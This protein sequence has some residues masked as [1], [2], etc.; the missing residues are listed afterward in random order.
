MNCQNTIVFHSIGVVRNTNTDDLYEFDV[1]YATRYNTLN[2][3]VDKRTE[4]SYEMQ[5]LKKSDIEIRVNKPYLL[6]CNVND[7]W[8]FSIATDFV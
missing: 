3:V 8:Y 6:S 5:L 4:S 2:F 1:E 7:I